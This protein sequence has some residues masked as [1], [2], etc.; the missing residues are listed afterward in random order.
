MTFLY[1]SVVALYLINKLSEFSVLL[2]H[3]KNKILV[4]LQTKF[5]SLAYHRPW[6][7]TTHLGYFVVLGGR[8]V[9]LQYVQHILVPEDS[10]RASV[11]LHDSTETLVV[12]DAVGLLAVPCILIRLLLSSA[13]YAKSVSGSVLQFP[14]LPKP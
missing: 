11:V 14:K 5:T 2:P 9:P 12:E 1:L 4:L 3:L 7:Y 8:V 6:A 10:G 13:L